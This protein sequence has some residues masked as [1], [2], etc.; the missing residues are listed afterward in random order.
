MTHPRYLITE[1]CGPDALREVEANWR[2][3]Y[4]ESAQKAVYHSYEAYQAYLAHVSAEPARFKRLTFADA[5]G[6]RAICP[7]EARAERVMGVP[8]R[9]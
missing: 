6:V 3:I 9:V 5:H 8:T 2:R 4:A 1:Y 7:L